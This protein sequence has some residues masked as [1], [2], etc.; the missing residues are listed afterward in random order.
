[1]QLTVKDRWIFPCM[2]RDIPLQIHWKKTEW[3]IWTCL[4]QLLLSPEQFGGSARPSPRGSRARGHA[5]YKHPPGCPQHRWVPHCS[6]WELLC[7]TAVLAACSSHGW[8]QGSDGPWSLL[9]CSALLILHLSNIQA[10]GLEQ[11]CPQWVKN[12]NFIAR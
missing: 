5:V 8:R 4:P 11:G 2:F 9:A 7:F 1:M 12:R 6:L 3:S 10:R